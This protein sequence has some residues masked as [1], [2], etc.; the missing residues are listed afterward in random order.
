MIA[1]RQ[2]EQGGIKDFGTTESHRSTE[3]ISFLAK[4]SA[5]VQKM[6]RE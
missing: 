6:D 5:A 3:E 4:M 1:I 2:Q